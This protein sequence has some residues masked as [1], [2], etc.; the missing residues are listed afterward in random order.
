MMRKRDK[1]IRNHLESGNLCD[2]GRTVCLLKTSLLT[3]CENVKMFAYWIQNVTGR[4]TELSVRAGSDSRW[5]SKLIRGFSDTW[6]NQLVAAS[7]P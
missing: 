7:F 3:F 2:I 5:N 1:L 6:R 4:W